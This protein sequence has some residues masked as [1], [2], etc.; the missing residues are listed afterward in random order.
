MEGINMKRYFLFIIAMLAMLLVPRGLVEAA[1]HVVPSGSTIAV[2][3]IVNKAIPDTDLPLEDASIVSDYLIEDLID[4]GRFNV[5][6]RDFTDNLLREQALSGVG[7]MNPEGRVQIGKLLGARY[8][9]YGS[10]TGLSTKESDVTVGHAL[11]G[12]VGNQKHKVRA[13]VTVRIIDVE[14]GCIVAAGRGC[15]SSS[16][17][18]TDLSVGPRGPSHYFALYDTF[19]GNAIVGEFSHHAPD[20]VVSIGT[21]K[22]ALEQVQNAIA[23]AADDA[24]YGERGILTKMDGKGKKHH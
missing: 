4:D 15:G 1:G 17:S 23:K 12:S 3:T 14:T 21:D 11:V 6:D 16:S 20:F 2:M 10:I 5:L 18:N 22:V 9:L 13:D 24:I 7:V 8:F 19:T